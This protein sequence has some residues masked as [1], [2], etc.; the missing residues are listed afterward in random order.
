MGQATLELKTG[1]IF[2]GYLIPTK[3]FSFGIQVE[4]AMENSTST[5]IYLIYKNW[6]GVTMCLLHTDFLEPI[7]SQM[8]VPV[9]FYN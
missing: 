2:C 3:A 9:S 8:S 5:S 6:M 7:L 4:L 1:Y